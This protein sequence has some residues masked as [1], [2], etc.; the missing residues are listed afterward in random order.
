MS[1]D[2]LRRLAEV[3]RDAQASQELDWSVPIREEVDVLVETLRAALRVGLDDPRKFAAQLL[4][5]LEAL[6]A[7]EQL[8]EAAFQ[9]LI[10]ELRR[11]E[12]IEAL[13]EALRQESE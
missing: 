6:G 13:L 10:A 11:Y 3:I 8:L 7:S 4:A 9:A 1:D 12:L 2:D 5:N